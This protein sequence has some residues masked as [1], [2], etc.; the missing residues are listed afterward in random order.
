MQLQAD[1]SMEEEG[2]E[3]EEKDVKGN[4][5]EG[6]EVHVLATMGKLLRKQGTQFVENEDRMLAEISRENEET[7]VQHHRAPPV[8]CVV[9]AESDKEYWKTAVPTQSVR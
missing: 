4:E 1:E 5:G 8:L 2:R 3:G 6:K 9:T 7:A